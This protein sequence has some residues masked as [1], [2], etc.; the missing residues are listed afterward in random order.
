MGQVTVTIAEKVYRIACDDGQ[1]DHLR[2][3]AAEVDAKIAEMRRGFGE[4]GD[5]R[6]T[7]MAAIT[8]LDEREE[9]KSK[10]ARLEAEVE[11]LR[12]DRD[13]VRSSLGETEAEIAAA[14]TQAAE[15]IEAVAKGLA[16]Q[17]QG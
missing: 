16:P 10:L 15:R 6:L 1:E 5:N 2:G 4:I 14:M 11:S 7:V 9:M 12:S 8:F 3:L 17:P 13:A